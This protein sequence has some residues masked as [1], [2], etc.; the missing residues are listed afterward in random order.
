[1]D[2]GGDHL[3]GTFAVPA[4]PGLSFLGRFLSVGVGETAGFEPQDPP[5][6]EGSP[7]G[8]GG[9]RGLRTR[10]STHPTGLVSPRPDGLNRRYVG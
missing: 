7:P 6:G 4:T 2:H 1:M 5:E 8:I 9:L 3:P 10:R